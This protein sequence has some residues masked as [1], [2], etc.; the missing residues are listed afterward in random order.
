MI[1]RLAHLMQPFSPQYH[2][3][4]I[5]T[6][7]RHFTAVIDGIV[8][9]TGTQHRQLPFHPILSAQSIDHF[10]HQG[11]S[12]RFFGNELDKVHAGA[13]QILD[14][15]PVFFMQQGQQRRFPGPG[16]SLQK[17]T[18][19]YK[20]IPLLDRHSSETNH[21]DTGFPLNGSVQALGRGAD[22]FISH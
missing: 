21:D 9:K 6:A 2:P 11:G 8:V 19:L 3:V 1:F 15:T 5:G 7:N 18:Q 14:Q 16:V 12:Q 22:P 13:F 4:E 20:G 10:D 17:N